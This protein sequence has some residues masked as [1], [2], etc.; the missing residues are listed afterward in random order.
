MFLSINYNN[1]RM[2]KI[3]YQGISFQHYSRIYISLEYDIIDKTWSL[4]IEW[5]AFK[6]III[7]F[8][9]YNLKR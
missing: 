9:N 8:E 6:L 4:R 2:W 3:R 7:I 1:S 5:K